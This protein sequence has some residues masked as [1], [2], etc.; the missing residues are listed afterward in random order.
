MSALRFGA[1]V[2]RLWAGGALDQIR[3]KASDHNARY[4]GRKI[5]TSVTISATYHCNLTCSHCQA[6]NDN[7]KK[8]ITTERFLRL[9]DEIADAGATKIGFTGGEPMIRRD[10]GELMERCRA[11]GLI[12]SVVAN[13]WLVK[14]NI[15][16]LKGLNLLFLSLDGDAQAHDA[17]RGPG[18]FEKFVESV[19]VAQAHGI[20]VAALT[21]L[22]SN[23]FHCIQGMA[24]I[25][26]KYRL[27]WMVGMIQT[28]F[29]KRTEQDLTPEQAR[30][31]VRI[32]SQVR[33]LRTSKGYLRSVLN[34][35][36]MERCWAGIGYCV[37]APNGMLYPCFP[38]QFDHEAYNGVAMN[39]E[40]GY[41]APPDH[42]RGVSIVDKPFGQ[43]F[44]ELLLYRRTC[45]TCTLA[46]HLEANYLYELRPDNVL[47]S[48]KLMK[49][50]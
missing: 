5:P 34:F 10:F 31:A 33:N 6:E 9:I 46:C 32:V 28:A 36:P 15:E 21:T 29:T 41:T 14:R 38:A 42:Y 12:T 8:D 44:D 27:H 17:I 45:D 2:L 25:V 37:I 7:S 18:N 13:G 22:M 50:A 16:Q 47:Q 20:P 48:F 3:V 30:E 4:R 23:N 40:N 49:P 1:D 26:T 39:K 43:A 19:E 35:S 24:D 11:R